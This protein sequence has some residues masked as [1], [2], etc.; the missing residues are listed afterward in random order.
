MPT[1]SPHPTQYTAANLSLH[2][3]P[4]ICHVDLHLTFST[5]ALITQQ[6]HHAQSTAACC[7]RRPGFGIP[8]GPSPNP[9]RSIAT[10]VDRCRAWS[11][12]QCGDGSLA[13]QVC[14]HHQALVSA[15]Q[16]SKLILTLR[17]VEAFYPSSIEYML[18]HYTFV[19]SIY[20][21]PSSGLHQIESPDGGHMPAVRSLPH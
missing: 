12:H 7:A 5:D 6:P 17:E 16:C 9:I 3:A 8:R 18:P 11:D 2:T 4:P 20:P 1:S 19:S 21:L 10:V 15:H 13:G 14:A